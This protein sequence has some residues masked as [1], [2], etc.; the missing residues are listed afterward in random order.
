MKGITMR[1]VLFGILLAVL[2]AF[3]ATAHG[4]NYSGWRWIRPFDPTWLR[5][6]ASDGKY[7]T[8]NNGAHAVAIREY[9]SG[10][11]RLSIAAALL[12][13]PTSWIQTYEFADIWDATGNTAMSS[14][15]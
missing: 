15:L 11:H 13:W 6:G 8:G 7:L 9:S 10:A 12:E 3:V 4:R 2:L 1:K 5:Q 14:L